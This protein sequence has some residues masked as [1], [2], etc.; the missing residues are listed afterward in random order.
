MP[1][2][3]MN[4]DFSDVESPSAS[5]TEP[6]GSLGRMPAYQAPLEDPIRKGELD[7]SRELPEAGNSRLNRTAEQVGGA[8][9]T[10]VSQARRLPDSARRGLHVVRDRAQDL[11]GH[12]ADQV[13]SSASSL[14]STAQE[15]VRDLS[16]TAR[17][18]GERAQQRVSELAGGL[19]DMAE[20]RGRVLLDKA[21]ELSSY[22][23]ER[24]EELKQQLDERTREL[25]EKARLRAQE[26]SLRARQVVRERP[27][28]CLGC[29]AGAAFLLG[30]TL[31]IMRS[32][33]GN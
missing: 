22:V 1:D 19:M 9:G 14:A 27:L 15:R 20:E 13:T 6:V 24:T 4:E 10:V 32:R 31:R 18:A 29:V 16:E 3:L 11:K 30:I 5:A 2:P 8:I 12:A 7:A 21:D 25:R 17:Q 23:S 28:E 26:A 33:N